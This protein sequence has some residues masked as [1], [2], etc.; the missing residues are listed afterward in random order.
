MD[1]AAVGAVT[2]GWMDV[3]KNGLVLFAFLLVSWSRWGV[4]EMEGL[5]EDECV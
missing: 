5:C 1:M 3:P 2:E 4:V